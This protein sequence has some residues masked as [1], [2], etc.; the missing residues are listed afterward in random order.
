[1]KTIFFIS[2]LLLVFSVGYTAYAQG[3]DGSS[4]AEPATTTSPGSAAEPSSPAGGASGTAG[5]VPARG[6]PGV[7]SPPS[8]T[9]RATSSGALS[10]AEAPALESTP[11]PAGAFEV[12]IVQPEIYAVAPSTNNIVPLALLGAALTFFLGVFLVAR[13]NKKSKGNKDP[14]G[15]LKKDLEAGVA[16]YDL[17]TGEITVQ[18]L[19][20]LE[21]K[22]KMNDIEHSLKEAAKESAM[23]RAREVAED[24]LTKETR[25]EIAKV[26]ELAAD[27]KAAYDDYT[28]KYKLAQDLLEILKGRQKGLADQVRE[29]AAAFKICTQGAALMG[30]GRESGAPEI[31]LH[32]KEE[33]LLSG[34]IRE[35][36][37]EDKRILED[38]KIRRTWKEEDETLHD[39]EVTEKQALAFQHAEKKGPWHLHFKEQ[40]NDKGIVVFPDKVFRILVGDKDTWKEAV[41]YGKALGI[42]EE[43]LDFAS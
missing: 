35:N 18:E 27:T 37:L 6:E 16:A 41:A 19:L 28:H 24:I 38:I 34:T 14:C 43:Q 21:L 40:G 2:T 13:T 22:K 26:A 15:A 33:R 3:A 36:S 10:P 25:E 39:V 31:V 30:G 4:G 17:I 1:M 9:P 8:V 23:K 42:P 5:V 12:P 7:V 20:V 32:G 29:R 11:T